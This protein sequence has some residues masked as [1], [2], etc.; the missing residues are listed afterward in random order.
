M[1]FCGGL[2][3]A[4]GPTRGLRVPRTLP[5]FGLYPSD[6]QRKRG[7]VNGARESETLAI[8]SLDI[9]LFG[10]PPWLE[11]L[12]S[13]RGDTGLSI[14]NLDA[15]VPEPFSTRRIH[16][17]RRFSTLSVVLVEPA[18]APNAHVRISR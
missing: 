17:S 7:A 9:L 2:G 3:E 13:A 18:P 12:T 8:S 15:L 11:C 10:D 1:R 5:L 14:T 6:D 16:F 4:V